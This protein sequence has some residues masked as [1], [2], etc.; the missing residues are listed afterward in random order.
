MYK[1]FDSHYLTSRLVKTSELNP[2]Y[3]DKIRNEL[4]EEYKKN[5]PDRYWDSIKKHIQPFDRLDFDFI[6][7]VHQQSTEKK[8]ENVFRN[9][10]DPSKMPNYKDLYNEKA[11]FG[12]IWVYIGY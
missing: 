2:L 4:K 3:D 12:R 6:G 1:A 9:L 10:E 5:I 11:N 8:G 7:T